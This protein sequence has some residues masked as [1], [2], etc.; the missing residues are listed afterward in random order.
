NWTVTTRGAS[1]STSARNSR[2]VVEASRAPPSAERAHRGR[3]PHRV[4][5][6]LPDGPGG[7]RVEAQGLALHVG[8]L[9]GLAQEQE[10]GE[11]GSAA[12]G[13]GRLGQAVMAI[14]TE[15]KNPIMI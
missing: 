7:Y 2:V 8:P 11:R 13:G 5:P 3:R 12:G 10:S 9:A 4:R 6:R 14:M 1:R 15:G